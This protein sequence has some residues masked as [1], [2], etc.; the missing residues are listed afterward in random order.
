MLPNHSTTYRLRCMLESDSRLRSMMQHSLLLAAEHNPDIHTNPVR[1][2]DDLYRFLDIFISSMPWQ[3]M[4]IFTKTKSAETSLFRRID[5]NIGYFYYLFDQPLDELKD[6][7]FVCPSLQYEP[8]IAQWILEYNSMW[9]LFLSSSHSWNKEYLQA[10]ISEPLFGLQNNWY[11]SPDNWHSFND[12]FARKLASAEVRPIAVDWLVSPCDGQLQQWLPIDDKGLLITDNNDPLPVKTST[13]FDINQLL[14]SSYNK[15]FY[16]G[17]LTHIL[18]DMHNYHHFHSPVD[19][20]IVEINHIIE[21]TALSGG[22]IIWDNSQHRY[23]YQHTDYLDYQ[24]HEPRKIYIIKTDNNHNNTDNNHNNTDDNE[25]IALVAVTVAQ[26]GKITQADNIHIG[27]RV[28][29]GTDLGH[30]LCGSDI[31]L[32]TSKTSKISK[33]SEASKSSK[34]SKTDIP[35]HIL[36]GQPL[37]SP[38]PF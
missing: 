20:T 22:H 33:A 1:T 16:G 11:E 18:L 19:G 9:G 31:L 36:I 12:F 30:F 5:Q 21:Y 26:V 8:D 37:P 25:Y 14:H 34:V 3:A 23:R 29:R 13:L 2:L 35:S 17:M 7:G 32:L 10:V 4:D 6:K 24:L 15:Y 38:P 27:S 28:Q